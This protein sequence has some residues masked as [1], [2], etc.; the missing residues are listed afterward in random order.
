MELNY[1]HKKA[2]ICYPTAKEAGYALKRSGRHGLDIFR[3]ES[4]GR[5]HLGRPGSKSR[6][7]A[8]RPNRK[9]KYPLQLYPLGE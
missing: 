5:Y 1:C 8:P 6:R 2:K 7:P 3:C 9:P 4:C